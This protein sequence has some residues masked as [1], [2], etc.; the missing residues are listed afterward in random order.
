MRRL[1]AD[2]F[3]D[4]RVCRL[5]EA[6]SQGMTSYSSHESGAFEEEH[7]WSFPCTCGGPLS[8]KQGGPASV[9]EKRASPC[10][11]T[12][13]LHV[14]DDFALVAYGIKGQFIRLEVNHH[15]RAGVSGGL[16]G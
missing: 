14:G 13:G 1:C 12:I 9:L 6:G 2:G 10:G 4:V 16:R 15:Y 8:T 3:A 7:I 5:D 11:G